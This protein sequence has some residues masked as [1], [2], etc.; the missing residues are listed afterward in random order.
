MVTRFQ[1]EN[2]QRL[3]I[4]DSKENNPVRK[5]KKPKIRFVQWKYFLLMDIIL[6]LK[7]P[8]NKMSLKKRNKISPKKI[9]KR[10]TKTEKEEPQWSL[11]QDGKIID[12]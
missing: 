1:K 4:L 8:E 11:E 5:S 12:A 3:K 2:K 10:K 7:N 6:S 9:W